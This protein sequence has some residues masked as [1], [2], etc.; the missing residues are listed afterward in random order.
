MPDIVLR[1]RGIASNKTDSPALE[2]LSGRARAGERSGFHPSGRL[3]VLPVQ[4]FPF[5]LDSVSLLVPREHVFGIPILQ[6]STRSLPFFLSYPPSP[7]SLQK[8]FLY[9]QHALID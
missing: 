9:F 2:A 4:S 3:M 5:S 6:L 1:A 7:A 8:G